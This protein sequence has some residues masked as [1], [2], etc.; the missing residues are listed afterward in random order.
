MKKILA[1]LVL[2]TVSVFATPQSRTDIKAANAAAMPSGVQNAI[3]AQK[4]RDALSAVI[5]NAPNFKTDGI[6][7]VLSYGAIG[8]GVADDTTAITACFAA[9]PAGST[10]IFPA[11]TYVMTNY[12]AIGVNDITV[13][14]YGATITSAAT[15]QDRK[16]SISGK[17]GVKFIG[18]KINGG[19]LTTVTK[20]TA[21]FTYSPATNPGSIHF[22]NSTNCLVESCDIRGVNWGVTILGSCA[23]IVVKDNDFNRYYC[24]VQAGFSGT[25]DSEL[26]PVRLK[27]HGNR[28][29]PGLHPFFPVA[30]LGSARDYTLDLALDTG[31][32]KIRGHETITTANG[33]F[34]KKSEHSIIGNTIDRPGEMG[35]ELQC[36]N[37]STVSANSIRSCGT[38]GVSLSFAQRCAISSNVVSDCLYAGIE[39]D[40]NPFSS[41]DP[42]SENNVLSGNVIDGNDEYGRPLH[43]VIVAGIVLGNNTKNTVISGGSITQ[44]RTGIFIR[45][46]SSGVTVDG[47]RIITND[48]S[49]Y[50][51][52]GDYTG[53]P[54]VQGVLIIDATK[55]KLSNLVL[56]PFGSAWQ[57]MVYVFNSDDISI[58]N[59]DISANNTC[60]YVDTNCD[61]V[62]VE[63]GFMRLG[64]TLGGD[65][66]TQS[67]VTISGAGGSCTGIKLKDIKFVGSATYGIHLFS[68]ANT[69]SGTVIEACDTSDAS[70]TYSSGFLYRDTY[71]VGEYTGGSIGLVELR[72]NIGPLSGATKYN[73]LF[74]EHVPSPDTI[75]DDGIQ[76]FYFI[77]YSGTLNLSQNNRPGRTV[78]VSYYEGTGTGTIHPYSGHTI[79]K[80]TSD[81]T[82]TTVG[83]K[84]TLLWTGFQWV[85]VSS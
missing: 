71:P 60:L 58:A 30:P 83:S 63:G 66:A 48:E 7:N 51:N 72:R 56:A 68:P 8:N 18:L 53:G 21:W 27:I 79:D 11:G 24:A 1:L 67:F 85:T 35:V 44:C 80:S 15:G 69:I 2:S 16:F 42:S 41:T 61:R 62:S 82:L 29:G 49:G 6:Y 76:E 12:V 81:K 45:G 37:D 33:R 65:A 78:T 25:G 73:T 26:G 9:A 40:G 50:G 75:T 46:G 4:V 14:G 23:D 77:S 43:W 57:R 47:V 5:D 13:I 32:I 64:T 52:T 38:A 36:S 19:E 70:C 54:W 84:T 20:A 59:C 39:I 55:V 74:W 22:V 28:F 34:F 31:A 3:T 17:S 10:I